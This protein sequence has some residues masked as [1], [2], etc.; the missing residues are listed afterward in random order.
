MIKIGN[1]KSGDEGH[2]CG[3]PSSLGNPF[4]MGVFTRNQA[5][6]AYAR[7]LPQRIEAQDPLIMTE[8]NEL[9][10]EY[11]EKGELTLLCWCAPKRCHC[12][13]IKEVLEQWIKTS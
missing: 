9:L 7:W 6:D 10:I 8:L 12:E 4:Y 5:C 11:K 1:K 2:Y 13:T 3:R